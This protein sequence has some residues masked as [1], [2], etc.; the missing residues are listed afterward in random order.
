MPAARTASYSRNDVGPGSVRQGGCLTNTVCSMRR[1]S[2][3][4]AQ[5][6]LMRAWSW[7]TSRAFEGRSGASAETR[8]SFTAIWPRWVNCSAAGA[9]RHS[10]SS[11]FRPGLNLMPRGSSRSA[12]RGAIGAEFPP[13]ALSVNIGRAQPS[14]GSAFSRESHSKDSL[15]SSWPGSRHSPDAGCEALSEPD[16]DQSHEQMRCPDDPVQVAS[17]QAGLK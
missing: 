5:A 4:S 15:N 11:P 12:R 1:T 17:Q 9:D 6:S 14:Q 3:S 2:C 13:V 7:K 8:T 10:T 16:R